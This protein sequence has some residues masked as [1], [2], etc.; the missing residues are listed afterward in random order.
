MATVTP[1]NENILL[2]TI[3][4]QKYQLADQN[5]QIALFNHLLAHTAANTALP[6]PGGGSGNPEVIGE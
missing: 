1:A 6:I 4:T 3:E 5:I 2:T